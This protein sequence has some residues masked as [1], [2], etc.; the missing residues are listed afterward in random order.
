M[1]ASTLSK[2]QVILDN[3]NTNQRMI[4]TQIIKSGS[5]SFVERGSMIL[6]KT[7]SNELVEFLGFVKTKCNCGN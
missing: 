6:V 7:P 5:Y 1:R 4:A 2:I 3:M